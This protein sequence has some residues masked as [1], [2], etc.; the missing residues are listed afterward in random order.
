M[1]AGAAGGVALHTSGAYGP[2]ALEPLA[3]SGVSCGSLHPLQ[4]VATAEQG[5]ADLPGVAFAVAG[6]GAAAVWAREIVG[7][8]EG[9]VLQIFADYRRCIT[10][11]PSWLATI[12]WA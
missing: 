9:R 4:T 11:L 5:V 3:K 10:P 12:W 8:L 7:L 2:E 6:D 1:L